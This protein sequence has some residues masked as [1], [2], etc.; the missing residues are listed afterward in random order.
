MKPLS[1]VRLLATPWTAAYQTPL[2][3]GFSRREYWSGLPLPSLKC[4]PSTPFSADQRLS[5]S[6]FPLS[7]AGHGAV[8]AL[9]LCTSEAGHACCTHAPG[10]VIP[11]C[12]QTMGGNFLSVLIICGRR[13]GKTAYDGVPEVEM[14]VLN[15]DSKQKAE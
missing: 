7:T 4:Q 5:H 11:D 2:S 1:R 13:I 10:L 3:M 9:A 12:F 8:M 6:L 14:K 15:T